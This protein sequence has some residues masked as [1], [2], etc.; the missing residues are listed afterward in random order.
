M[1]DDKRYT[2]AKGTKEFLSDK[3]KFENRISI[4]IYLEGNLPAEIKLFRDAIEDK[5]RAFK[6]LTGNRIE[7]VFINPNNGSETQ[8]FDSKIQNNQFYYPVLSS[9]ESTYYPSE[10]FYTSFNP[11]FE[12]YYEDGNVVN[13]IIPLTSVQCGIFDSYKDKT[14]VDTV[15]FYKN[16]S[17]V[18]LG[19]APVYHALIILDTSKLVSFVCL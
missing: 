9:I 6:D 14:I 17:N 11:K 10:K 19:I 18:L 13:I 7:Y 12:I 16:P 5:L 2:L 15:P 3:S 1:T 8:T 4:K